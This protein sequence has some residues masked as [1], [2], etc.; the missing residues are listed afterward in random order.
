M[1]SVFSLLLACSLALASCGGSDEAPSAPESAPAAIALGKVHLRS[2]LVGASVELQN[3]HGELLAAVTSDDG[4]VFALPL[5]T[6]AAQRVRLVATGGSYDGQPFGERLLLD[7]EQLGE[8]SDLYVNAATTLIG[9]YIDRHPVS[10][11]ADASARVKAFLQI[12]PPSSA[13]FNLD[14]PHQ[15]YF[16]H[17]LLLQ[18]TPSGGTQGL[19]ATLDGLVAEMDAGVP[20]HAFGRKA[21]LAGSQIDAVKK[22]LKFLAGALADDGISLGF[23]ALFTKLGIDGT[24]EILKELQEINQ[25]LDELTRLT[26]EVL[27]DEKDTHLQALV[28]ALANDVTDIQRMY[29]KLTLLVESRVPACLIGKDAKANQDCE[30]SRQARLEV[31]QDQV[32]LYREEI[33]VGTF[34]AASFDRKLERIANAMV[35]SQAERGLLARA[36]ELQRAKKRFDVPE[37]DPDLVNIR[38]YYQTLQAMAVHLLV[39]ATMAKEPPASDTDA[40]KKAFRDQAK[41]DAQTFLDDFETKTLPTQEN[42]MKEVRYQRDGTIMQLSNKLIWLRAPISNLRTP[43]F[44]YDLGTFGGQVFDMYWNDEAARQCR[45]LAAS[46]FAGLGGWRLPTDPEFHSLVKGSPND[47]GN[48]DGGSGIFDWL[49]GQGFE[50]APGNGSLNQRGILVD[51]SMETAYFSSTKSTIWAYEALWDYG[52]DYAYVAPYH[53]TKYNIPTIAGAW[54]VTQEGATH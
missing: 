20:T 37:D 17:E 39:E 36:M 11:I 25:K 18:A 6:G 34:A 1:K 31:L 38:D 40:K 30:E 41:A 26:H 7:V 53:Y 43:K 35:S 24:A 22:L 16:R 13:G 33:L 15:N 48:A 50:R 3:Q 46:R 14:N 42:R 51:A 21:L 49:V 12:P 2:P 10:S 29:R 54:C 19:G 23:E 8:Q 44:K 45:D 47:S 9:R 4:G 32:R 5:P 28:V 52:V 27:V